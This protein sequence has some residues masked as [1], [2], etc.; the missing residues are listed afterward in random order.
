[1]EKS[2]TSVLENDA[3]MGLM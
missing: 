2:A 3:L 1:M